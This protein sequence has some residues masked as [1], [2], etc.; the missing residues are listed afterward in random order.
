MDCWI[1]L[2]VCGGIMLVSLG[3]ITDGACCLNCCMFLSC[4]REGKVRMSRG[5]S[6]VLGGQSFEP[7][8]SPFGSDFNH[9][10][11]ITHSIA[12]YIVHKLSLC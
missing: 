7:S 5:K 8:I 10:F 11:S 6:D 2:S 1:V 4:V 3:D 12:T 9:T